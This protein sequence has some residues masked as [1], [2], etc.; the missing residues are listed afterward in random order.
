MTKVFANWGGLNLEPAAE[1]TKVIAKTVEPSQN[2]R[3][4]NDVRLFITE[5]IDFS[6]TQF[7]KVNKGFSN[8][9]RINCFMNVIL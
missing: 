9:A 2:I 5:K 8:T 4:K 3:I 7:D 1:S 6:M